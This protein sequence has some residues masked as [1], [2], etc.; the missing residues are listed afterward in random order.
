MP[1]LKLLGATEQD[2]I[3]SI[4]N[5]AGVM[6]RLM[7][8]DGR[9]PGYL[10]YQALLNFALHQGA[11]GPGIIKWII[12]SAPVDY[13]RACEILTKRNAPPEGKA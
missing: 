13:A 2:T 10:L 3:R 9:D 5:H 12:E 11:N 7:G 4:L 1:D 6:S 8:N